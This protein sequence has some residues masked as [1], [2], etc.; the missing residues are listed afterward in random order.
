[1]SDDPVTKAAT[2]TSVGFAKDW[3]DAWD[4][5][6][7][8]PRTP[9][10]LAVIRIATGL[11]MLYSHLVIATDLFAFLGDDAWINNQT[12]AAIHNGDYS[13]PDAAR[14]YLWHFSNPLLLWGHHLFTIAVTACFAVGL[15]TRITAPLAWWLQ[16]ML[17]HRLT[18]TLFGLDQVVTMLAMYLML[19]PCGAVFSVD[20]ILR[21]KLSAGMSS[22][23]S[24]S[25]LFPDD[26]PSVACNVATRLIQLH[27]CII[28]LF[29]G[30]W[31]ARG[32]AWWDGT[33]IWFAISNSQYQSIDITWIGR[34]PR[35]FSILA[36][37]TVFW[38]VFY[39]ALIWPKL[40]RPLVLAIAIAVHSG[41]ALFLGMITFGSIMIVANLAFISPAIFS[42]KT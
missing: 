30:L 27:L 16:L 14:S 11:M 18:G 22:N 31:K 24:W 34:Y 9:Q 3:V 35:L 28:Y 6:W 21:K 10:T 36:H 17:V 20:A 19:A 25:W 38:E 1:M 12:I 33:A 2:Y 5:F 39:C 40:T 13:P 29:G 7:F 15:L 42:R 8:A 4:Q 37:I 32:T 41:I 23:K 26:G